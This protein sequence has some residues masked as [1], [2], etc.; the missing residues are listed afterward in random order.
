M[1]QSLPMPTDGNEP[2]S[3][4]ECERIDDQ[5]LLLEELS[6]GN[7]TAEVDERFC[8]ICYPVAERAIAGAGVPEHA[9]PDVANKVLLQVLQ[10]CRERVV[11]SNVQG[12][13]WKHS[14]KRALDWLRAAQRKGAHES[15]LEDRVTEIAEPVV[16]AE[17][18]A[19]SDMARHRR[20]IKHAQQVAAREE[21][22]G[23]ICLRLNLLFGVEYKAL[24]RMWGHGPESWAFRRA[25]RAGKIIRTE[26]ISWHAEQGEALD[27]GDLYQALTEACRESARV[28]N[29]EVAVGG[30]EE[31]VR[32]IRKRRA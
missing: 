10:K 2:N 26:L 20:A 23:M 9:V 32:V 13:V 4:G 7:A 12:F 8:R 24:S 31:K 22:I 15:S 25:Q 21:P 28:L 30:A 14:R 6:K 11:T 18:M 5:L 19:R 1:K 17:R 3:S 29:A 16:T 27:E